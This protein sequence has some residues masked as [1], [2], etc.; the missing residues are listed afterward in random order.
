MKTTFKTMLLTA[1]STALLAFPATADEIEYPPGYGGAAQKCLDQCNEALSEAHTTAA[2][3][4]VLSECLEEVAG[5]VEMSVAD[6]EVLLRE[7]APDL[8]PV[9]REDHRAWQKL[10]DTFTA[11]SAAG[12]FG[13]GGSMAPVKA[14]DACI[15]MLMQRLEVHALLRAELGEEL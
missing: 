3:L 15:R 13:E 9:F 5:Y 8:L 6:T 11:A 7:N 10:V 12:K 1:A 14:M 2:M 4:E